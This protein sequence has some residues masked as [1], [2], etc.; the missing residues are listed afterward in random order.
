MQAF[1]AKITRFKPSQR[2]LLIFVLVFAVIGGTILLL[3]THAASPFASINADKGSL[4]GGA[5]AIADNNASDGNA[6]KFGTTSGGTN[7]NC[8]GLPNGSA[9]FCD[10]FNAPAPAGERS[11]DLAS[12]WGVSRTKGGGFN[13]GQGYNDAWVINDLL[14]GTCP[15]QTVSA[16][17]D[18]KICNGQ[19]NE[20]VN[21]NPDPAFQQ[22]VQNDNGDVTA[23]TMYPKQPFDFAGRTGKVVFDVSDDSGG[24][25]SAWP[26]F[27]MTDKPVPNPFT[28]FSSWQ[29]LPQ[30]GFGIR[31]GAACGPGQGGNC[32]PNCPSNNNVPV[33][34]VDSTVTIK[35]YVEND[36]EN[37]INTGNVVTNRDNCI[38]EPT[39]AGQ[40]NHFEIDVSQNQLDVYGT[41]AGTTTPL[42][43][44]ATIPNVSLGF[45][46]GLIWL[47]DV[48]YNGS[49]DL[50][51]LDANGNH[52]FQGEHTFT[53]DNVGFDGPVLPRDL[54]FEVPDALT[55]INGVST[56]K[57]LGWYNFGFGNPNT[58]TVT[59]PNVSG[60]TQASAGLLVF[61]FYNL[62][63]PVN[64]TYSLNGHPAHAF[65]WPFQDTV[66]N[67]PR[68]IGIPLASLGEV[69]NG[70]NTITITDNDSGGLFLQNVGLIMVGAGGIVN[71]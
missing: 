50:S 49:K 70:N 46:R 7:G 48:H 55:T 25:H 6:V 51:Y 15:N 26:E 8:P 2:N 33:V 65:N 40:L 68:T 53:W 30:N 9:A 37:E 38:K 27:W 44:L 47:E 32:A 35:N 4:A 45:T 11:G 31:L 1:K 57:N 39:Q 10:T 24:M 67:S 3:A 43:H 42:K 16:D 14:Q 64:F 62:H 58:V 23:L 21:D 34:S 69:V 18:V 29:S 56:M 60:V 63:A 54:A 17:N 52:V 71:P 28:H 20:V 13:S 19:L 36:P 41:D 61:N 59:A 66:S 12:V 22:G 5:L